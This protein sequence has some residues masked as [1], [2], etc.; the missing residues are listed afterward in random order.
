MPI[1]HA[2]DVIMVQRCWIILKLGVGVI[3]QTSKNKRQRLLANGAFR[4]CF[5]FSQSKKRPNS[6]LLSRH[7]LDQS[8]EIPAK[9]ISKTSYFRGTW[10]MSQYG[11][12]NFKGLFSYILHNYMLHFYF[13]V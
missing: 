1:L 11:S 13:Q 8:L 2:D 6:G 3:L 4:P 9:D 7:D 5:I 12:V 10:N